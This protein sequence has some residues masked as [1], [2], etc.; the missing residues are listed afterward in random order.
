MM[1]WTNHV[2][3]VLMTKSQCFGGQPYSDL[4][5]LVTDARLVTVG[6][7]CALSLHLLSSCCILCCVLL[8]VHS[9]PMTLTPATAMAIYIMRFG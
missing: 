1:S 7:E 4:L 8:A 6:H 2:W 9:L 3:V 5:V